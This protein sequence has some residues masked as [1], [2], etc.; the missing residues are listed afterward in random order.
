MLGKQ[1]IHCQDT[2]A[3]STTFNKEADCMVCMAYAP[4]SCQ[5]LPKSSSAAYVLYT[6]AD[7]K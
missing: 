3:T 4:A 2:V 5:R 1:A 7:S 6:A